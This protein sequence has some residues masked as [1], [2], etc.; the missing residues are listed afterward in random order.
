MPRRLLKTVTRS[1]F[2]PWPTRLPTFFEHAVDLMPERIALESGDRTRSM[3]SS[4]S[5]PTDLANALVEMGVRP[6]DAVGLYSRNTIEAVEAMLVFKARAVL[7]NVNYRYV[8]AELEHI[9]T[10]SGNEGPHPR[11]PLHRPCLPH[12]AGLR[13]C[14]RPAHRRRRRG[15]D[16]RARA[17]RDRSGA[18]GV[19]AYEELLAGAADGRD[20][21][22]R[23]DDDL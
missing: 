8:E 11:G 12:V 2:L 15:F 6:G 23:T 20:F 19:H 9:F 3:P 1:S 21:G 7:V 4:R 18:V 16:R 22:V 10:D 5:A 13:H 14:D 17:A